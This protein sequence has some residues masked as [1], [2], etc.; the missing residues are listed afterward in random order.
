[1][2]KHK[3]YDAAYF[4]DSHFTFTRRIARAIG[5]GGFTIVEL[6]IV[7]VVIGILA[8]LV[9]NTLSSA[10][11]QAANTQ[12]VTTVGAWVKAIRAYGI[13]NAQYPL[14]SPPYVCIGSS[15]STCGVVTGATACL[16]LGLA[17]DNSAFNSSM[18]PYV[19]QSLPQTNSQTMDCGGVTTRG[20]MYVNW[21]GATLPLVYVFLNGNLSQCPGVSG[22][23]VYS[24]GQVG[25][26]TL[27]SYAFPA[28]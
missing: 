4:S 19:G 3:A 24:R 10:R 27:C 13:D 22:V 25:T 14:P 16:G 6:L 18:A 7:I 20:A 17:G 11:T 28:L 23:S 5:Q 9:L 15:G 8:A 1:M 12:T 26:T 21:G 2:L